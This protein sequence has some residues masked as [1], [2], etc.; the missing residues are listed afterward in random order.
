LK[1]KSLKTTLGLTQLEHVLCLSN[2]LKS[3]VRELKRA[4][5]ATFHFPLSTFHFL[6]VSLWLILALAACDRGLDTPQE[7][8]TQVNPETVATDIFLT[9]NA[10]PTGFSTVSFPQIDTNL[11]LLSGWRYVVTL[12]FEGVFASTPRETSAAANAE[13]W[14]NQLGSARRVRLETTGELVGQEE[15]RAFE[16]VRLGP[17]AFLVRNGACQTNA[18]DDAAQAADLGAG[19]LIGGV[20]QAMS[21]PQHETINVAGVESWKFIFTDA[22]LVLP[23]IRPAEGGAITMAAPGEMWVAPQ[24]NAVMRFYVTLDVQTVYLFD[25]QL[26]VTGQ[27]IIRYDLYDINVPQNIS[28]PF[29]C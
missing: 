27:V 16:A 5:S 20:Q 12:S 14:F 9:Q 4:T 26:P 15:N 8:P 6:S 24:H 7:L 22:D 28:V 17:D 25:R 11:N 2:G 29:G 18:G 3:I 19:V 23:N 13:V 1:D 10:P 21:T